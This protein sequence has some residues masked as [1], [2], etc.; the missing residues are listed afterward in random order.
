MACI[1]TDYK[2]AAG[3]DNA[4]GLTAITALTDAN[5]VSFVEPRG[6]PTQNRGLRQ[7]RANG[8]IARI[9]KQR[10]V[11]TSNLLIAQWE[12]LVS[13]YEGANQGLVTIRTAI[14]GTSFANFNAVLTLQDFDEMDYVIFSADGN[15]ADFFGAGFRAAQWTF[16]RLVAL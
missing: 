8:T 3:N 12:E 1:T 10:Q 13:T 15:V 7:T 11:W 2:I 6:I 16:T 4:G 14:N 9:G 5:S